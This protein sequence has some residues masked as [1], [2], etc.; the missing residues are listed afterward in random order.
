[1]AGI[2]FGFGWIGRVVV[3]LALTGAVGGFAQEAKTSL[4][5]PPA[6]LLPAKFGPWVMSGSAT[7]GTDG[8]QVD[9]ANA[10][11]LKEFGIDRFSI[12]QY[13]PEKGTGTVEVKALQFGDATGAAA[14]FTFYRRPELR[15]LSAGQKLGAN[16]AV[17]GNEALFWSGASLVMVKSDQSRAALITDLKQLEIALP[18]IGGPRG[19]APLLPTLLPGKGLESASVRYALGPVSYATEG[20]VLPPEI[21]GWEKSGEVVTAKYSSGGIMTL[22]LYPTPQIAGD[23][24]RAIEAAMNSDRA[25]YG[26][27]K[28]RR[29]GPMLVLAT[30][31]F[32]PATEKE[33][34]E[35]THLPVSLTW[36]KKMPLEFHAEVGKTYSLLSSIA[37]FCGVGALAAVILG[38]FLGGGRA[39]IRVLQ[40]KPAAVEP[41]FLRI[42]LRG[43][44][45]PLHSDRAGSGSGAGQ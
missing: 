39:A 11:A 41:E 33:L 3:A 30:G 28:L 5:V 13:A 45:T 4:V 20:G 24:G 29:E 21:P 32:S 18:K 25:K 34:V 8:G 31:A 23:R 22:L 35:A 43:P 2:K 17:S 37:A 6:P 1:M 27:V 10:A 44:S 40:G 14:A 26:T 42:D 15:G 9:A 12:A 38:L 7:T 16:A 36:D 19:S